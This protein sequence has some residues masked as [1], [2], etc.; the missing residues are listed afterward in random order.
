MI[1]TGFSSISSARA[2]TE[3]GP[4]GNLM[5]RRSSAAS[6]LASFSAVLSLFRRVPRFDL[7]RWR[8]PEL[9]IRKDV[10]PRFAPSLFCGGARRDPGCRFR[11]SFLLK[12]PS[13]PPLGPPPPPPGPN[14][15][16]EDRSCL[17]PDEA[18][19]EESLLEPLSLPPLPPPPLLSRLLPRSCLCGGAACTLCIFNGFSSF[20]MGVRPPPPPPPRPRPPLPLPP[21]PPRPPRPLPKLLL[22][23][24]P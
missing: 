16:P 13:P 10:L 6:A 15:L 4:S 17:P 8:L 5:V 2:P 14:L 18:G 19:E 7:R 23:L 3:I 20:N 22:P 9:S 12:P 1:P 11:R 24:P 21:R